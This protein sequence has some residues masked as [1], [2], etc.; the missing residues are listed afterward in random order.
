M[1]INELKSSFIKNEIDKQS[2][3]KEMHKHH[4]TLFDFSKNLKSTDVEK[5]EILSDKVLFTIKHRAISPDVK[6][7][8]FIVDQN[9][10]RVT[11]V[12]T[13]NFDSYEYQDFKMLI[14]L[15]GDNQVFL[16]VG[17]NVGFHSLSLSK[18]F[19]NSQFYAFEPVP[20]TFNYLDQNLQLNFSKNV[21][22][23][24]C[25]IS[26]KSGELEFYF[27]P[28]GSGN[29][30]SRNLSDREDAIKITSPVVTIDDFVSS[31]EFKSK[32][33]DFIKCDVEGAELFAFQGA[34]NS[35]NKFRPI[36]FSEILR[37]W[38]KKF[39]YDPNEIFNFFEELNY[40]AYI[41][42]QEGRLKSFGKM[43]E[44][45]IET[46]FFFIPIEKKIESLL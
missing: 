46:N 23:H 6:G 28:E 19:V 7:V 15:F 12:E 8:V 27:Y 14:N 4:S 16:D 25:G 35:I 11:P 10:Q 30:S 39:E 2:F 13:F 45:T 29:A 43:D 38:S 36:V 26:D 34:K 33:I 24:N 3:I 20:N 31:K 9:D 17:A 21:Q 32:K 44:T 22:I 41:V 18:M 40:K 5:I 37:K 42:N 1:K